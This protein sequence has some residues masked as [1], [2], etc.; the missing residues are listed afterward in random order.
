MHRSTT[1]RVPLP[2]TLL[3][4]LGVLL[5]GMPAWAGDMPAKPLKK[6][7]DRHSIRKVH[8]K[9]YV[10]EDNSVVESRVN[11]NRDVQ[12]INEGKA[13]KGNESGVQTWTINR[14]TYGSHDGT[15]YP[16]RG[17][18]IHELNRG[19]FKALGIYNEMKDTP[20]AKEV[21]DK[22]K[23]PEADRKAALKAFKAG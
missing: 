3:L 15:L 12:D 20:R 9:S 17:D 22:M 5:S 18:G 23:V 8:Q 19:A 10:R 11:I 4:V 2:M 21:L 7:A 6:P 1:S 14:R 16:M 13:K